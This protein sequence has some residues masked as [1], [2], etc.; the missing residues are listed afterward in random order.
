[1]IAAELRLIASGEGIQHPGDV[2]AL[3][4]ANSF[5]PK[6]VAQVVQEP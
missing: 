6:D 3:R 4:P 2:A 5:D 1:M